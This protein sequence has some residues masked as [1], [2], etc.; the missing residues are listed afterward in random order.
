[1]SA[2][3]NA[4]LAENALDRFVAR[5]RALFARESDPEKRWTSLD[6]ILI[7]LLADPSVVEASRK[8]PPCRFVDNRFENFL[9][10]EDPDYGFVVNGLVMAEDYDYGTAARIH[11]HAHLYTLYGLLDGRQQIQRYERLDDGSKPDFAEIRKTSDSAC[12]PGMVDLVRPFEVHSED[13]AGGG[14]VA[15]LII[16]SAKAGSFLQ[17]RYLPE[18]NGY[19]QGY[20]PRQMP[21]PFF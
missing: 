5:T 7:E 6:P 10:Y 15:A 3:T 18:K 8:W 16:R 14:R 13:T 2:E 11:D 1:M 9:F 17:G 4:V 19:W 20:G 12:G 21:T